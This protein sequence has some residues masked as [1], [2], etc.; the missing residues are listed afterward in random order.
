MESSNA[1]LL[2]FMRI[3]ND[4]ELGSLYSNVLKAMKEIERGIPNAVN[5]L[6]SIAEQWYAMIEFTYNFMHYLFTMNV[7]QLSST[8]Y[9]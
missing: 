1:H 7:L 4:D 2:P 3:N 6:I 8:S 9:C 5:D